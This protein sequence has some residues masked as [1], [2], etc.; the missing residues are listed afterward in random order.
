MSKA[1]RQRKLDGK[2]SPLK[3]VPKKIAICVHCGKIASCTNIERFHNEHCYQNPNI[4]IEVEKQIRKPSKSSLEKRKKN[5]EIK[6]EFGIKYKKRENIKKEACIHC[7][8]I[9]DMGNLK[10]IHNDHCYQNPNIDIEA[11]KLRR[12]NLFKNKPKI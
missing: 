5:S 1:Q 4:N 2:V 7:G 10:L 11:E 3:G 6:K 12:R 8:K 9:T